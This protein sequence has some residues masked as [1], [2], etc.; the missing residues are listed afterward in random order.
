MKKMLLLLLPAG[1]MTAIFLSFPLLVGS[2]ITPVSFLYPAQ[3]SDFA[4]VSAS[5]HIEKEMQINVTSDFPVVIKE[6]AVYPGNTVQAGEV[7]AYTD[8]A[9]TKEMLL[10]L[11]QTASILPEEY[12]S[13]ISNIKLDESLLSSV[14][15]PAV[16]APASG[17]VMSVGVF[18]GEA[19]FPTDTIAVVAHGSALVTV[20]EVDESDVESVAVG[21]RV[22]VKASATGSTQYGGIVTEIAPA[23]QQVFAG[24][25]GQIVVQV[26]VSLSSQAEELRPGY[27]VSAQ[28]QKKDQKAVLTLPYE[29]IAQDDS[30]LEYVYV[31]ENGRAVRRNIVTGKEFSDCVAI[32]SGIGADDLIIEEAAQIRRNGMRVAQKEEG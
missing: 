25:Q 24:T 6:Y 20:L 12:K 22:I 1:L 19:A 7:I 18:V 11:A 15:P 23:A 4:G 21:D 3:T 32:E 10:T 2:S 30:G 29:S 13:L 5:G 26:R 28:I 17:T 9:Q 14:I 31:Y 8:I 16:Y 27:S